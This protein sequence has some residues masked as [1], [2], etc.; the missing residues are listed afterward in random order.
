MCDGNCQPCAAPCLDVKCC[1]CGAS[2]PIKACR[3]AAGWYVGRWCPN[4]GPYERLSFFYYETK[5]EV[6][7]IIESGAYAG[8]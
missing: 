5:E 7:Q 4:C 2:L 1:D 3:S 6:D 8:M